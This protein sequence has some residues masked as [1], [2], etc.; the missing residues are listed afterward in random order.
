VLQ[1]L[2]EAHI[3]GNPASLSSSCRTR[4]SIDLLGPNDA[5]LWQHPCHISSHSKVQN[6][7]AAALLRLGNPGS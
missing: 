3:L 2:S 4:I 6:V 5:Q 1:L 7:I